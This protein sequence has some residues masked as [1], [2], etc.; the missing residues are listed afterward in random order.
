VRDQR[1]SR[2]LLEVLFWLAL[3]LALLAYVLVAVPSHF[4]ES[5]GGDYPYYVQMAETP[6][7]N[8]VPS[9]WRYRLLNPY[10]ASLLTGAGVS[11]DV[12]FLSLTTAFAAVSCMLM[13]VYLQQLGLSVFAAWTG[14]LL[15]AVSVGAYIPLRRYYGYTDALTNS[16]ILLVLVLTVARRHV[17]TAVAL[18]V[19]TLAKESMLLLLPFLAQRLKAIKTPWR[20]AVAVLAVPIAMFVALR[21]LVPTEPSGTDPVAL[22]L[23]AQL[24]YWRTA[25]VNGPIR[26][27]LW[28]LAYSMGPVW[29]LAAIG[30]RGNLPF[31]GSTALYALPVLIPLARTTDTERALMLL[32]PIVFPLAAY[33]LQPFIKSRSVWVA[34]VAIACTWGAQLTF[35]WT[36]QLRLGPVN[37]KDAVFAALCLVPALLVALH[38]RES[39]AFRFQD[40]NAPRF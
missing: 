5:Q 8:S 18:G 38:R 27:V 11:T 22:T 33:A 1:I 35:D 2:L 25:M 40:S 31:V 17:L 16:L 4:T 30:L 34:A 19:G 24:E 7:N 10:F 6:L 20:V 12:A 26:W 9:P 13:R 3:V 37:A 29:L 15:F 28:S 36:P 39:G 23:E 21:V 32:F 14:A